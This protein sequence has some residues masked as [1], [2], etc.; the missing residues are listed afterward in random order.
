MDT[1]YDILKQE[2]SSLEERLS[3]AEHRIT[4]LL[5]LID[6]KKHPFTFHML[7]ADATRNQI[8]AIYDLMDKA[9]KLINEGNPMDHHS[10]E[11]EVYKIIPSHSGD[12]HFAEGIVSTL[13][14]S[15]QYFDVYVHYKKNGMNL[16]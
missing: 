1:Q 5:T 16:P 6:S 12:Y 4:L 3:N 2:I 11:Q 7:E 8:T 13:N 14:S 9:E 10:F 15:G